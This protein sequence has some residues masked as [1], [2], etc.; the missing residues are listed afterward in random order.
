MLRDIRIL[1][2]DSDPIVLEALK[3][4]VDQ[5]GWVGDEAMSASEIVKLVNKNCVGGGK[6]YDA[7]I[8]ALNFFDTGSDP[9][10][11]GVTA[12]KMIRKVR[13][14]VPIVFLSDHNNSIIRE[15]IRRVKGELITKPLDTYSLFVRVNELIRW[16]RKAQAAKYEG[17][18]R[19]HTSI[20]RT[21]NFRRSTDQGHEIAVPERLKTIIE[22]ARK[23]EREQRERESGSGETDNSERYGRGPRLT[24]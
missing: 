10:L 18:D 1:Y 17:E 14:D 22:E 24:G 7:I 11:T 20:N 16:H 19:R 4:M 8:T 15:E 6:C 3:I 13:K 5:Y 9:Y 21:D 2:A 12:A 23:D